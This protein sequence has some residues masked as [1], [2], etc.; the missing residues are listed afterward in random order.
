[1]TILKTAQLE[2]AIAEQQQII[3]DSQQ[4]LVEI[5]QKLLKA[6]IEIR[7]LEERR[8]T[9]RYHN[10]H[11]EMLEYIGL[12]PRLVY[13][14]KAVDDA[15]DAK[16]HNLRLGYYNLHKKYPDYL[17]VSNHM[18]RV[19]RTKRFRLPQLTVSVISDSTLEHTG[20]VVTCDPTLETPFIVT[21]FN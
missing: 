11:A 4:K 20:L 8:E 10:A 16:L 6:T 14:S 7:D 19:L 1:M 5:N 12:D 9:S 13:D 17:V 18:M 21:S 2:A 3:L 15:I